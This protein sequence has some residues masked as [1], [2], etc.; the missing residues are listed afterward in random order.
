MPVLFTIPASKQIHY[1]LERGLL[2]WEDASQAQ[3]H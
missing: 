2:T 3:Y 1:A